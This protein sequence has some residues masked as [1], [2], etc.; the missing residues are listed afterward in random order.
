MPPA[1]IATCRDHDRRHTWL[2]RRHASAL[3]FNA[4][5]REGRHERGALRDRDD[6]CVHGVAGAEECRELLIAHE[7][8][9]A[10]E[11]GETCQAGVTREWHM[12]CR[13]R[14]PSTF[15]QASI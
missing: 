14:T 4:N 7:T 1:P 5:S 8:E 15:G 6:E 11:R 9:Q 10:H 3:P 2:P 12:R 13:V